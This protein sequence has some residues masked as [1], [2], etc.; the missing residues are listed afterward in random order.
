MDASTALSP[1]STKLNY[2]RLKPVGWGTT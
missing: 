1:L 2:Y